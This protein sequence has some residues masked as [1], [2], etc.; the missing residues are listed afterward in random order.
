MKPTFVYYG[1]PGHGGVALAALLARGLAP[2]L[3]ITSPP[4]AP[5]A[6][7]EARLFARREALLAEFPS[8]PGICAEHGLPCRLDEP[9]PA[10]PWES[11]LAAIRPEFGLIVNFRRLLPERIFALPPRGTFNVHPSLL[12]RGRG[13]QPVFWTIRHGDPRSGFTVHRVEAGIDTGPRIARR[14]LAVADDDSFASLYRRL[15]ALLPE[16]VVATVERLAR[17]ADAE[18]APAAADGSF[19]PMPKPEDTELRPDAHTRGEAMRRIRAGNPILPAHFST[20]Q[21]H[22]FVWNATAV[23]KVASIAPEPVIIDGARIFL[24]CRDGLLELTEYEV[25]G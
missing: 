12:P 6:G 19:D 5:L 11:D 20:A 22:L 16:L 3:V 2:V 13:P 17:G 9:G 15:A 23:A 25:F 24:R 14:E 1:L 21:H 7:W 18:A 10:T 8:I 4:P